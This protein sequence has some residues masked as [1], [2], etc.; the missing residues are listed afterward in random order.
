MKTLLKIMLFPIALAA[1]ILSVAINLLAGM[2]SI[3]M[4]P[5]ALLFVIFAIVYVYRQSWINVGITAG[6]FV[7]IQLIYFCAAVLTGMLQGIYT[8]WASI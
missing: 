3:I 1:Q 5:L 6:L 7:A 2:S 4:G 8:R